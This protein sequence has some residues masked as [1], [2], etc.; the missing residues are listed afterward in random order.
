[1]LELLLTQLL[2]PISMIPPG[3]ALDIRVFD[4]FSDLR[5][6]NGLLMEVTDMVSPNLAKIG[7]TTTLASALNYVD[8]LILAEDT[9]RGGTEELDMWIA[10]VEQR[11]AEVIAVLIDKG[12]KMADARI[13][14]G[15]DGPQCYIAEVRYLYNQGTGVLILF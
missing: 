12:T 13:I 7:L 8:L 15:G 3:V 6:L 5:N 4:E 9:S 10:R 14:A 2:S 1:M 11:I